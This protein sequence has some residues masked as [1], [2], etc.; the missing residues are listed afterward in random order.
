M[1]YIGADTGMPFSNLMGV[2]IIEREKTRVVGR[3]T[4]RDDP[5]ADD[6][7]RLGADRD[8]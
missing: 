1:A 4:V 6:H 2:E 3:L 8:P 7:R 5:D